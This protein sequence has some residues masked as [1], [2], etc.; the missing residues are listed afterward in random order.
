MARDLGRW[1]CELR[2]YLEFEE[3]AGLVPECSLNFEKASLYLSS[4]DECK[5]VTTEKS[6]RQAEE[7]LEETTLRN[8]GE[9][10]Q[11]KKAVTPGKEWMQTK[12]WK[13]KKNVLSQ[14]K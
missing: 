4:C 12:E 7:S 5:L 3:A 10:K 8:R 9:E 14:V 1:V 11:V 2:S 6:P 13:E